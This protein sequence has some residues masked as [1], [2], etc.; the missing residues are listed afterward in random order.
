MSTYAS[1]SRK[2]RIQ[3]HVRQD[4]WPLSFFFRR[5]VC[6]HNLIIRRQWFT[7]GPNALVL[8]ATAALVR[9]NPFFS[10]PLFT[11]APPTERS[12][13]LFCKPSGIGK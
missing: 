2:Y 4:L 5:L 6:N 13:G 10:N 1:C 7:L 12:D 9:P 11:D 3:L 8:S